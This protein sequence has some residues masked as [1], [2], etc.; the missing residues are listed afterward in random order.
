MAVVDVV[1]PGVRESIVV[2]LLGIPRLLRHPVWRPADEGRGRGVLLVPGF[3]FGDTSLTLTSAWLRNRG[4]RPANAR[5]GLNVGC[6][7]VLVDRLE[8]RLERFA[9]AT[10]GRVVLIG[11]SWGGGL[12]RL[13]AVR[14]PDLVRGLVMLATPVL[15]PLE[16]H[17]NVV[18]LARLLA[19]LSAAGLPGLLDETCLAGL[20]FERSMRGL[21]RPLRVPATMVYSREDRIVPARL[22]RDPFAEHVEVRSS[23]TGMAFD[24]DVYTALAPQLA[25]WAD[26]AGAEAA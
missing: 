25:T 24:P 18:R 9:A 4:Y 12:A 21:A 19:R 14:R 20:C 17:P 6:T 15:G 1:R 8:Q 23:H 13:A 7:S 22:C 11:Q 26:D 3:G 10:A 5:L 2:A 16:A